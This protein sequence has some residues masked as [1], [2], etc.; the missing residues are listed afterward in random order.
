MLETKTVNY[1]D[2]LGTDNSYTIAKLIISIRI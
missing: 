1:L 2:Q